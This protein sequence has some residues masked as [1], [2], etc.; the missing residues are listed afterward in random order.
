[1]RRAVVNEAGAV[2]LLDLIPLVGFGPQRFVQRERRRE[3]GNGD[4]DQP[5]IDS[6][7]RSSQI[8]DG[9][10]LNGERGECRIEHEALVL[11]V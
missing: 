10:K 2:E 3:L 8:E 5:G 11:K 7:R 1:M 4:I 9:E 6:A